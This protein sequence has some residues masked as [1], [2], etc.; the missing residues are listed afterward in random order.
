MHTNTAT[1]HKPH[2][3]L[4]SS[5]AALPKINQ[6]VFTK[7]QPSQPDQNFVIM[8]AS[9]TQTELKRRKQRWSFQAH[10]YND[11][12]TT[13]EKLSSSKLFCTPI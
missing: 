1:V 3:A 10:P 2:V 5:H 8:L 12:W 4:H 9:K 7:T 11:R 6:D 13:H